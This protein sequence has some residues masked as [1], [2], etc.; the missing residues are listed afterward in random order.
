[1]ILLPCLKNEKAIKEEISKDVSEKSYLSSLSNL[2][3]KLKYHYNID[4]CS[5]DNTIKVKRIG[6]VFIIKK[7]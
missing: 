6:D 5:K 4:Y 2:E 3:S 7:A 1:M